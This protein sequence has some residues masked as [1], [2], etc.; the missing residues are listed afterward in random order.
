[1]KRMAIAALLFIF[2]Q[3]VLA[4]ARPAAS[5]ADVWTPG[6]YIGWVYFLARS[7]FDYNLS[8][9]DVTVTDSTTLY[10]EVH[11][12]IDCKVIDEAGNGACGGTFPMEKIAG[13]VG[14]LASPGCNATWH[15]SIRASATSGLAPLAPLTPSLLAGGFSVL[16]TPQSGQAYADL[17]IEASGSPT[18]R[19]QAITAKTTLGIPE[20]PD[21]DFK[22][23]FHTPLTAGGTC[24]MQTFPRQLTV[25][26]AVTTAVIEQCEW[27]MFYYD[28][29]A[30]LP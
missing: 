12:E 16:F 14:S 9:G 6:Q 8:Q 20:W 15:E 11:G 28:P 7:D 26:H 13:R 18:C 29:Y 4:P 25:G 10:H 24:N 2:C 22:V 19:S 23:G 21:L 30:K 5:Q 17:V 27:R 1:M 3:I